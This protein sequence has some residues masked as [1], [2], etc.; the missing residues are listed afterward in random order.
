MA[1]RSVCS[2][3]RDVSLLPNRHHTLLPPLLR[4]HDEKGGGRRQ[5]AARPV[6][7][8]KTN[9][10]TDVILQRAQARVCARVRVCGGGSYEY[11]YTNT[12][13]STDSHVFDERIHTHTHACTFKQM[14]SVSLRL[15]IIHTRINTANSKKLK[16]IL[17]YKYYQEL[18]VFWGAS[19]E[20]FAKDDYI[21]ISAAWVTWPLPAGAD[22][23]WR[24]R[25]PLLK[26]RRMHLVFLVG[27]CSLMNG[28]SV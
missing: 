1:G 18:L 6:S 2:G 5:K 25:C 21:Y 16:F 17:V 24:N 4:E 7:G 22:W 11:K 27:T 9:R 10:A 23:R 13:I 3:K 20:P 12:H 26:L 28:S 14:Y 8:C 19:K 15:R